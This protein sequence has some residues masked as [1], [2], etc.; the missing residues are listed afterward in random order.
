M[1]I[2]VG[3]VVYLNVTYLLA[4]YITLSIGIGFLAYFLSAYYQRI[5]AN[6]I[7][8]DQKDAEIDVDHSEE[9]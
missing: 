9:E 4:N 8:E 1:L 6:Y 5:F 7:P 2:L 3:A